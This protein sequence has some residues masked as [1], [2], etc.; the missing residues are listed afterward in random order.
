LDELNQRTEKLIAAISS[1][2]SEDRRQVSEDDCYN[3]LEAW[4]ELA[5]EDQGLKAAT[6]ARTLLD[7]MEAASFIPKTSFYDVVL[8]AY[9]VSRGLQPAADGA[10]NLLERMLSRCRKYR[11][12]ENHQHRGRPPPEPAVKTFNIVINCWSKV[13]KASSSQQCSCHANV[14]PRVSI[15]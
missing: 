8:Q 13:N 6:R 10:Q 9:A 4:M 5:K 14:G 15:H 2:T 1:P 12:E 11:D 3:V 7:Q